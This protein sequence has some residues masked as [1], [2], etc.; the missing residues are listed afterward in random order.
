ME[1]VKNSFWFCGAML[2]TSLMGLTP[3]YAQD[4][5]EREYRIEE[6][7]VPAIALEFIQ[8]MGLNTPIK[9][10]LEQ[11]IDAQTYEAKT[12]YNGQDYSIEFNNDG[13]IEDLEITI[14]FNQLP[15]AFKKHINL[16]LSSTSDRFKIIKTQSQYIS[17]YPDILKKVPAGVAPLIP[18]YELV[19]RH[20]IASGT[21]KNY[22]YLINPSGALISMR[23]IKESSAFNMQF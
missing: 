15:D 4:K 10:Y 22:E 17:L 11:G 12:T 19:V 9:W 6:T 5:I 18:N 21:Y 8:A 13:R 3:C 7:A 2:F 1:A 23:E 16:L 14:D 20:R